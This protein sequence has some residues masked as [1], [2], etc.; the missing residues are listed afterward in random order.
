MRLPVGLRPVE[1]HSAHAISSGVAGVGSILVRVGK[2]LPRLI[3]SKLDILE[4][5]VLVAEAIQQPSRYP[6]GEKSRIMHLEV[7][8]D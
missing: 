3:S 4:A 7:G 6:R 1:Q 5:K 2:S 8:P